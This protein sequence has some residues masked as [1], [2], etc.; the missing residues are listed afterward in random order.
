MEKL[1]SSLPLLSPPVLPLEEGSPV[2]QNNPQEKK[3]L[4]LLWD[5]RVAT[6]KSPSYSS[7][8]GSGYAGK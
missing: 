3:P 5:G 8:L 4:I 7:E 2:G 1:P 6:S